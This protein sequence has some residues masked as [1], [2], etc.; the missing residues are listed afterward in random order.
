MQRGCVQPLRA[1]ALK[2]LYGGG[3]IARL[4]GR[5]A[6]LEGAPGGV[7]PARRGGKQKQ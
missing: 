3:E 5:Y 4:C 7:G 2:G 1:G 6:A